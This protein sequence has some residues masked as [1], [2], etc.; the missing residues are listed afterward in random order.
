MMIPSL[1][2]GQ[3]EA[4]VLLLFCLKGKRHGGGKQQQKNRGIGA[5]LPKGIFYSYSCRR[6]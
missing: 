1:A 6:C 5:S 4:H 3:Q 2:R